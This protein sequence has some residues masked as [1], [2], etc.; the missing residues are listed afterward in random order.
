[1]CLSSVYKEQALGELDIDVIY[2][3]GWV[4]VYQFSASVLFAVPSAIAMGLPVRDLPDNIVDG[5]RCFLG[6]NSVTATM[7]A[8]TGPMDFA[9]VGGGNGPATVVDHCELAPL[10]VSLYMA[11]N[12][13]YNVVLIVILKHGS[14][15]VL[16]LASTI[17]V[18]IGN[19]TFSLKFVPGHQDLRPTD[20]GGLVFILA[21]LVLYRFSAPAIAWIKKQQKKPTLEEEEAGRKVRLVERGVTKQSAIYVGLNQ[22][23]FLEPII[24]TRVWRAQ[25][26]RLARSPEQIRGSFL[27]R[28]GIPPS[29]HVS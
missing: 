16:W 11:F 6:T 17:M 19:V 10:F 23:E 15:N 28:L 14:A 13:V 8:T 5:M 27:L 25:R 2:L 12:I 24:N 22:A 7:V 18:P 20:I 3:N 29:P 9:A 26:A 1:M 21:G 4:A